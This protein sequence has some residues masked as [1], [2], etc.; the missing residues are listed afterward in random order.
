VAPADWPHQA[1]KAGGEHV[2][3]IELSLLF[4]K[5]SATTPGSTEDRTTGGACRSSRRTRRM[6]A[7]T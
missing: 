3:D 7:G 1:N 6:R 5:K 4:G 2:K